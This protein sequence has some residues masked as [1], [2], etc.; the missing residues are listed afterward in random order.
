MKVRSV[1]L[2]VDS[3]FLHRTNGNTSPA[4]EFF[5]RDRSCQALDSQAQA[6]RADDFVARG[7]L[8]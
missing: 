2:P 3:S 8:L 7:E 5:L 1:V 6:Q 4:G